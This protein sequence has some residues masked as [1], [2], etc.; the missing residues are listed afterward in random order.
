MGIFGDTNIYDTNSNTY[1]TP[2]REQSLTQG[3]WLT[4]DLGDADDGHPEPLP[5][6]D[7]NDPQTWN[8]YSYVGNSP[9]SNTDPDGHNY[10]VCETNGKNCADLTDD[11]YNQYLQSIEG[12]N[13][14]VNAAGKIQYTND[15]GSVTNLGTA[16]YYNEKDCRSDRYQSGSEL[17]HCCPGGEPVGI[18][19]YVPEQQA[20]SGP[21]R[22]RHV[23]L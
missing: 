10:T 16:S 9:V 11:Q 14:T 21:D 5:Y 12:T 4:P 7:L 18:L 22:R 6:S 19:V 2:N 8:L 13:T 23:H 1:H 20:G 17:R 3:R 15:N